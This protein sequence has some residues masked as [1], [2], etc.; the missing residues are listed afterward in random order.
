[1]LG[2]SFIFLM[3][4]GADAES[5]TRIKAEFDGSSS[6]GT[7]VLC[8]RKDGSEFWAAVFISPVR[9]AGGDTVQYFASL[10]DPTKHKEDEARSKML[11]DELNH[12]VNLYILLLQRSRRPR[13]FCSARLF[14]A[15]QPQLV[16]HL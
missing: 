9:D 15:F 3:A 16:M 1:V 6:H 7:E 10:I 2:K 13:F 12:R 14:R 11:I 8:R 4:L 5:V